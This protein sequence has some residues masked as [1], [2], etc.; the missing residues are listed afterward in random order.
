MVAKKY[1]SALKDTQL[2]LPDQFNIL[3]GAWHLFPVRSKKRDSLLAALKEKEIDVLIHYP[4][5]P[6]K[7]KAYALMFDDQD[8]SISEEI[9]SQLLSLP[10]GP[11]LEMDKVEFVIETIIDCLD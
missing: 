4:V 2:I 3:D 10:I 7:Q 9:S 6:H 5:P 8:F 1:L 11:H